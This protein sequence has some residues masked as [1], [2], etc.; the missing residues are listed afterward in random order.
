MAGWQL[1]SCS[2]KGMGPACRL[3]WLYTSVKEVENWES[4]TE[5]RPPAG[6]VHASTV[7]PSDVSFS[8]T[9]SRDSQ[10]LQASTKCLVGELWALVGA[11]IGTGEGRVHK[12]Q[13]CSLS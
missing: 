1:S 2:S 7:Q 6:Q 3:G 5:V 13:G 8:A 4:S 10:A 9:T 12:A 11:P